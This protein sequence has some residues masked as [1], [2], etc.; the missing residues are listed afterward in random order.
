V[1]LLL[2]SLILPEKDSSKGEEFD[3]LEGSEEE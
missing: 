3:E 1:V 2:I